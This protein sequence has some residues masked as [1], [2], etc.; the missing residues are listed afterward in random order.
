VHDRRTLRPAPRTRFG[1]PPKETPLGGSP[2][3]SRQAVELTTSSSSTQWAPIQPLP[4]AYL[5]ASALAEVLDIGHG[6]QFVSIHGVPGT[7]RTLVAA[8]VALGALTP[9]ATMALILTGS[10]EEVPLFL[11]KTTGIGLNLYS[12][13]RTGSIKIYQYRQLHL[14]QLIRLT[15]ALALHDLI[16]F[17]SISSVIAPERTHV[18][19]IVA[20]AASLSGV[21]FIASSAEPPGKDR[22]FAQ[23]QID[24]SR[25]GRDVQSAR[26]DAIMTIRREAISSRYSMRVA[27]RGLQLWP[28]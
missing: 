16:L 21:S 4:P 20:W 3:K 2:S 15:R 11:N 28:I 19:P 17:D 24:L 8:Q 7:G 22:S 5:D 12:Y 23:V 10:P 9:G 1:L 27:G 18:E 14:H 25:S 13:L 6:P 26:A